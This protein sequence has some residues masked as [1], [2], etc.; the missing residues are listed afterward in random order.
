M[1][2]SIP[3]NFKAVTTII[4]PPLGKKKT[5]AR[6]R[7]KEKNRGNEEEMLEEE[8]KKKCVGEE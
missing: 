3:G 7:Y 6:D 5:V 1:L 4:N 8:T 2:L